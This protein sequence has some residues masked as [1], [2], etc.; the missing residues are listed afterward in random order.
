MLGQT[1]G[2]EDMC[3]LEDAP[4][5]FL[6]QSLRNPDI[7]K[8]IKRLEISHGERTLGVRLALDGSDTSEYEY[9]LTQAT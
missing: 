7:A 2:R 3:S 4:G 1:P 8:D 9:C 6:L 5:L